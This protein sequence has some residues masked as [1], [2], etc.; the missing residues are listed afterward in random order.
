MEM[1]CKILKLGEVEK[2]TIKRTLTILV[3]IVEE[4]HIIDKSPLKHQNYN[5]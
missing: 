4:F 3:Y 1:L 5:T 2:S